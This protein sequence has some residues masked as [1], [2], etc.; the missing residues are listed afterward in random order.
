MK[1]IIPVK[2]GDNITLTVNG[3]GS[4]GEGVGKYEGFT[5]FV[6]G[7]LPEEEVRVTI[8]LVKKS[9]AVGALEEI[10]K[11]SAE[12][13][14]PACPVYKECGGCQLQHLSYKGQLECKRQQVQDALTRIGHLNLEALPV[15]G[16]AEPWSYRNKMQFP[17]A[18]DAEG[19]LQIGCYAT[20]THS[21]VD[22]DACM[23]S[24]E[25]NN[26]IMKTVR[27]WMQHYNISAYDEKTGKGLV[28]HIMGRV[29]V[30]SGEV[31]A[32][33]ITSGYDIPHRGVLI[34]W[35]KRHVPGL[36]SVVQNINKKQTNVVMGSKTRVL[37]G[38]ES[39][40]DSLGS[41]SFHISAQAFFQVNSEQAEK[42]YNKALEFA[43]LSGKETVVDV[44]CGTGTISLYLARHA[45]Q[46]YGIEIVAPA[47]ENAKKNAEEN[48]CANAE[49]ICGDAAVE[50]PKL[51]AGGVRPDVVVVDPPRA[52]CEQKVLAAIAEVQPERVVYVSCNPASLAR[53]LAFMEQHGYK[54][55]VA[56]PV[57]MFPMTSHVE[58]VVLLGRKFE[59]S[60]EHVYL[61]YEPSAEIDLPG[62]ATYSEIKQWIQA[63]YD[64]KVSSLYVAQV[65]QKHGIVERECYNKPKSENAKQPKCPPEK[66]AAIEAA[67]KH[68]KMI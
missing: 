40:K 1:Q 43:A 36:V 49:F 7:A 39:I 68:F 47:I 60:C 63:E 3:L 4:S 17:A 15:L 64:L 2:Q 25:A 37:Y 38:P 8:T 14:E 59:K 30:H 23:I 67:L 61:D 66:E 62:G 56:Q 55:I 57:D 24:K 53:D 20:A 35:L 18:A 33:I 34:E 11:A 44:Y 22:T 31:M 10:V 13:V 16:A 45:K 12:R 9:Y 41:L 46:V 27:T 51:L 19:V 52:G 6:K 5:V 42:L 29:G 28:R 21:V 48:K 54:A 58:T 65:K 50:L 26:A 32:V